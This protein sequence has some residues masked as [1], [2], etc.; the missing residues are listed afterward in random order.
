[1]ANQRLQ[2]EHELFNACL[3]L[4]LAERSLHLKRACNGD[5]NFQARIER[6]LAAHQRAENAALGP[7]HRIPVDAAADFIGAYRLISLLGEGGMGVVLRGRATG[8]GAKASSVEDRQARYGYQASCS[9][10]RN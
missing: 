10:I 6:L 9:P 8:A 3:E 4:T 7:L 1:M 5:S 2:R